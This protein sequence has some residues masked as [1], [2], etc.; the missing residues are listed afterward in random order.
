M[1]LNVPEEF[2]SDMM[3]AV[4]EA[5]KAEPDVNKKDILLK[6]HGDLFEARIAQMS[7]EYFEAISKKLLKGDQS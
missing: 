7:P 5:F 3:L 2:L 1:K 6:M 4:W